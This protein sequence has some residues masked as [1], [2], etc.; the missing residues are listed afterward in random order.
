[1]SFNVSDVPWWIWLICSLSAWGVR[2][3][4]ETPASRRHGESISEP[5]AFICAAAA[6]IL[7]ILAVA[8]FFKS[9]WLKPQ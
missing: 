9:I 8:S 2:G 6:V 5:F 3:M 1:M 4:F 7:G